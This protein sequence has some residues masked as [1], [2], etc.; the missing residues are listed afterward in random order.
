MQIKSRFRGFL[1]IVID[2]ETGGFTPQKHALLEIAAVVTYM[3]NEGKLRVKKTLHEHVEPFEGSLLDPAAL[4]FNNIDP[5]HPL[6]FARPEKVALEHI[7]SAVREELRIQRCNKAVLV[8]HNAW[9][10]LCFM[11]SAVKRSDIQNDPFHDFTS[12]DT[13]TLGALIY[14][15]TIL[16]R[17]MEMAR[18]SFNPKEAHSALYDAEKTAELFCKMVNEYNF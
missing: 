8:G 1:P 17:I 6:R 2:V 11:K 9:F 14:G 4:E 5:H 7:F 18:V 16:A 13:A 15:Q 3:D 12:F 10:D